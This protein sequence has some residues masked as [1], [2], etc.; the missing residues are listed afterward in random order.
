MKL[1]MFRAVVSRPDPGW[2]RIVDVAVCRGGAR[3]SVRT[4]RWRFLTL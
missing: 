3:I 4:E 1:S 2:E